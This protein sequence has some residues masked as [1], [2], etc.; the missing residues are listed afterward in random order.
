MSTDSDKLAQADACHDDDAAQAAQL[1]R[2]ID[3]AAIDGADRPLLAFLLNHVLGE[4]CGQ[5][6]EAQSRT[7]ARCGCLQQ[8][9]R[10]ACRACAGGPA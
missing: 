10:R 5:W 8:H 6:V 2:D 1:L 3:A 7:A 4:K 9:R